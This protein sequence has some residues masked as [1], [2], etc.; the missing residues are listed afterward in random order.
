MLTH[1]IIDKQ[2]NFVTV[3]Q[4]FIADIYQANPGSSAFFQFTANAK[5]GDE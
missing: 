5:S 2:C 4:H 3:P 1:A